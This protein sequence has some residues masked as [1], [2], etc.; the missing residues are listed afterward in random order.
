MGLV[1]LAAVTVAVG[2]AAVIKLGTAAYGAAAR[3]L[4]G[5]TDTRLADVAAEAGAQLDRLLVERWSDVQVLAGSTQAT[6]MAPAAIVESMRAASRRSKTEYGSMFVIDDL[7][8]L[9]VSFT[10][11]G[12]AHVVERG[13]AARI[14][15]AGGWLGNAL[16]SARAFEI[17]PGHP[18]AALVGRPAASGDSIAFSAPIH[19]AGNRARGVWVNVLSSS[20]LESAIASVLAATRAPDLHLYVIDRARRVIASDL[21]AA[22]YDPTLGR[23]PALAPI[24]SGRVAAKTLPAALFQPGASGDML[25][26]ASPSLP[27]SLLPTLGWSVV[28]TEYRSAAL[29]PARRLDRQGQLI[30]LIA[31]TIVLAAAAAVLRTVVHT[32][33]Q[34]ARLEES[35]RQSQK[36]E[37]VGRLAGSI[38]HDFNNVLTV[39]RGNA[40]LALDRRVPK[41]VD[42]NLREIVHSSERASSLVRQ[43]LA[44]SRPDLNLV[45]V[46]DVN[47]EI[48]SLMRVL[49]RLI[50]AKVEVSAELAP[51]PALVPVD[52][53]QLEQVLVNLAIN[54][55]DAMPSGGTLTFR[56][57]ADGSAVHVEIADTGIGMDDRTRERIFEP[58]FTT[59]PDGEGTGLGL[60]TVHEIVARA[61][62]SVTVA[63][64][65][66]KGTTFA[67]A[68]PRAAVDPARPAEVSAP[69][70]TRG[71]GERVLVV[72]DDEMVRVV[73]VEI[74]RR[75]GYHVA[76]VTD[77][78]SALEL[79]ERG[80]RF[81]LFVCDIMLPRMTGL[82]LA[83]ELRSREDETPLVFVSGYTVESAAAAL[84]P[85]ST[86]IPK[87]F[88]RDE[89]TQAA[90]RLLD[91]AV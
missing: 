11:G 24:V 80:E 36:I 66:G 45:T 71:R 12:K 13:S 7:G 20:A 38:A 83:D 89:L 50:E 33:A 31:A 16:A 56:T 21:V 76:A 46:V 47:E 29:A 58:F 64:T 40:Q 52:P 78:L 10:A 9:V 48:R 86:T 14:V 30:A 65:V 3:S 74:L 4:R 81:D 22:G 84:P 26:A 90:R 59:K 17:G 53:T 62:G 6:P 18:L 28:A 60:A 75:A 67:I 25:V 44:F 51:E 49:P 5:D 63:S 85:H 34:R 54:A 19:T 72:E 55:R 68:L 88:T 73:A 79:L 41:S 35:L 43:L 2:L 15:V 8:R 70:S 57:Y 87:P 77:G 82:E 61:G 23:S 39:I 27:H 69:E 1:C 37:A 32:A 42:A 91:R